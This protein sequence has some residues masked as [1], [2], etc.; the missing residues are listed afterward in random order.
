MSTRKPKVIFYKGAD[1][2]WR[3]R[4][5]AANGRKLCSPGESF[6][7]KR[8]A[9]ENFSNVAATFHFVDYTIEGRE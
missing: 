1:K 6:S 5:V 2:K 4:M 3:W 9:S 7:S 8:W